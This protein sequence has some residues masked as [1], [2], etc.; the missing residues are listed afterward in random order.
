MA[1]LLRWAGRESQQKRMKTVRAL[2]LHH[3]TLQRVRTYTCFGGVEPLTNNLATEQHLATGRALSRFA[4]FTS[5]STL[6]EH[7]LPQAALM[8]TTCIQTQQSLA[9]TC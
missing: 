9:E 5:N 4:L 6:Q 1:I 3:S 2:V 7:K 8:S